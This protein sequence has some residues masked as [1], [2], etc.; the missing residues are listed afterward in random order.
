MKAVYVYSGEYVSSHSGYGEWRGMFRMSQKQGGIQA[1]D[2][3]GLNKVVVVRK[4]QKD[5]FE[6][7]IY[8]TSW[9]RLKLGGG[10]E[11]TWFLAWAYWLGGGSVTHLL[12][13]L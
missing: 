4:G 1:R 8:G 3:K 6:S 13:T 12:Q 11:G 10:K 7:Q 5:G 9:I 2:D